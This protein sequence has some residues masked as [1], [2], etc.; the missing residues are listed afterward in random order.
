[1]IEGSLT[2]VISSVSGLFGLIGTVIL[3]LTVLAAVLMND[4]QGIVYAAVNH[5][6]NGI[7]VGAVFMLLT[8]IAASIESTF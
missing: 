6:S 8:A 2:S 7:L 1:M 3:G 5:L 4:P